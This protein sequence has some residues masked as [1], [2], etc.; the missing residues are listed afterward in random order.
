MVYLRFL[1]PRL[2]FGIGYHRRMARP[3]ARRA[4]HRKARKASGT[5][6][7]A[8]PPIA[9][10]PDAVSPRAK[11][12]GEVG[13]VGLPADV[14]GW[15]GYLG[16][17]QGM[18]PR[19]CA[20]YRVAVGLFFRDDAVRAALERPDG[21]IDMA[22]F[23]RRVVEGWIKRRT[24][25]GLAPST[26]ALHLVALRSLGRYLAGHGRIPFNPLTEIRG[27]R[28]YRREARPLT[29]AEVR[30]MFFGAPGKP[31]TAPRSDRELVDHV[32]FAVHYAGALRGS[33]VRNLR[34]DDVVWH[35]EERCYSILLTRTKWARADVRQLLDQE[36]SRLL[37]AYL[38]ER[39]RIAG[40]VYLFPGPSGPR[41]FQA[42]G[43]Y[44]ARWR[45]FLVRRGIE[46]KGRKL[47][48][49]ILRHSAATHMLEAGW[50]LRAVQ[51]RLRHRSLEATQ[52]YLHTSDAQITRLLLRKPPLQPKAARKK[53]DVPGALR[54]LLEGVRGLG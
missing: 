18:A 52:V 6:R 2:L 41:F 34:T 19:T 53:P 11:L 27:P 21:E 32:Q 44:A 14:E 36:T 15:L 22:R 45:A 13:T 26:V 10:G 33:E 40:G 30:Q 50:P 12:S 48:P 4:Q 25:A 1:P 37:G 39:P 20:C 54:A 23:D 3:T 43:Y 9:V 51:E 16:F 5:N 47:T 8:Q 17:V 28:I 38:R 49:H 24:L 46:P 31:L 35:E 42:E 7:V 29:T